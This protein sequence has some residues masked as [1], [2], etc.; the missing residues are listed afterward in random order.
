[1]GHKMV[2]VQP[3]EFITANGKAAEELGMQET[4]VGRYLNTLETGGMIERKTAQERTLI[5]VVKW[6]DYQGEGHETGAQTAQNWRTNGAQTATDK[7]VNNVKND[8]EAISA[9]GEQSL[10]DEASSPGLDEKERELLGILEHLP[11]WPF[12]HEK[13]LKHIRD[14]A[15]TPVQ[16]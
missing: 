15:P 16:F 5:K 11:G 13:D 10:F 1:M 3:A 12:D 2:R 6:G 7:N 14:V 9:A 8:E 4:T